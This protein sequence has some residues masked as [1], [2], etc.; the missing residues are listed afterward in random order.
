ME[1]NGEKIIQARE[2]DQ[3]GEKPWAQRKTGLVGERRL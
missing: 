3:L 1:N 2:V